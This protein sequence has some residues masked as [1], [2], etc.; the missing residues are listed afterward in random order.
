MGKILVIGSLN[1]DQS[2]HVKEMPLEGQTI[3]GENL[4]FSNGGKGANQACAAGKLGGQVVMLGSIG[5]DN[6]G[7]MQYQGLK[8]AGVSVSNLHISEDRATGTAVIYINE[9]GNNCIVVA[10]GANE[11][12]SVDYL[13]EHDRLFQGCDYILLQMEIPYDAVFY[14]VRRG[15]ELGKKVVLNPAPAPDSLPDDIWRGLYF[16]TPNETELMTLT[17]MPVTNMQ[18]IRLAAEKLLEKGVQ[19]VLVTVGEEGVVVVN[20]EQALRYPTRPCRPVDTTA[21][22]DTFNAGFLVSLAEGKEISEAC[23]FGN[24]ASS[25]AVTRP[26]AQNSIPFRDEVLE[27]LKNFHPVPERL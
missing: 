17:G 27:E 4:T 2:V 14:A 26:G 11:A 16:I 18:Q 20:H 25:I 24:M 22:G 1:M 10:P 15:Q 8:N 13:K 9:R 6:F 21:A 5:R 3:L 7:D 12:C 19:N 23:R